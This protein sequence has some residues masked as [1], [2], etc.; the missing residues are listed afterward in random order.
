MTQYP[1][2]QRQV[3]NSANIG[4]G[5]GDFLLPVASPVQALAQRRPVTLLPFVLLFGR[6]KAPGDKAAELLAFW[7]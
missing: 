5:W 6:E 1:T 7:P 3:I 2:G 4:M